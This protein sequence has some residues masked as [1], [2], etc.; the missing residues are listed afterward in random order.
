M[1]DV[2]SPLKELDELEDLE[3][4]DA[5]YGWTMVAVVSLAA[6]MAGLNMSTLTTALPVVV[7]YFDAGPAAASWTV[8]SPA[9]ISTALLL[10]CGRI[11]DQYG[12]RAVF[13]AAMGLYAITA[14]A[15]G[16]SPSIEVLIVL[17]ILQS[18]AT[19]MLLANSA[20]II[21]AAMPP[22]LLGSAMGLYLAAWSGAELVGPT[23]GGLIATTVGWRWIFWFNVPIGIIC[24]VAAALL[25]RRGEKT[26]RRPRS[27]DIVG[28]VLFIGTVSGLVAGLSE[29]NGRGWGDPLVLGAFAIFVV[30]FPLFVWYERRIDD[31]LLDLSVF[32]D[33][34]FSLA[35]I[36]SVANVSS[37]AAVVVALALYF[38]AM[39]GMSAFHAGLAALPLAGGTLV[40]SLLVGL[41]L[42]RWWADSVAVWAAVVSTVGL[43]ALTFSIAD[44]QPPAVLMAA[45]FVAGLG[46]GA[47][48]PANITVILTGVPASR[49]GTINAI[50]MTA[51]NIA[52]LLG[53]AVGL[54]VLTAPLSPALRT[55][56]FAGMPIGHDGPAGDEVVTAYVVGFSMMIAVALIGVLLAVATSRARRAAWSSTA[57]VRY[58]K[59]GR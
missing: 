48:L 49:M 3:N 8:L 6:I 21:G 59:E 29:A 20:A 54:V 12:R 42:R 1:T 22:R 7:R 46:G 39:S 23:V 58:Q 44:H 24:V 17:R 56:L 19:A 9:L 33:K 50:R 10:F 32:R 38:Q 4:R 47:F 45:S 34:V 35:N 31:P 15:S 36:S 2:A 5:R 51:Q 11:S 40:G 41:V 18:A 37:V 13:I 26:V 57:L 16:F 25:L 27:L 28:N 52:Y 53:S 30:C 14:L 55:D 43:I